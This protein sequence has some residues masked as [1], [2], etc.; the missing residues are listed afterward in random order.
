MF[1]TICTLIALGCVGVEAY[2]F[3]KFAD[4]LKR[5]SAEKKAKRDK[6]GRARAK[7]AVAERVRIK[8]NRAELFSMISE[9]E[10]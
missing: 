10:Y 5:R 2:C 7:K 9:K 3:E 8:K 4:E 6:I 1:N